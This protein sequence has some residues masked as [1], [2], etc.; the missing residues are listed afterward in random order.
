MQAQSASTLGAFGRELRDEELRECLDI[1]PG[2]I[3]DELVGRA[4]AAAIWQGLIRSR[5]FNC[6]VI[7][8]ARRPHGDRIVCFGAAAFVS[9]TFAEAELS[10]PR[11]CLNSRIIAS[12]ESERSVVLSEA[13]LR[14][15]NARGGL[16]MVILY[17]S[18]RRD[19]L[20]QA[21]VSEVCAVTS[22]RFLEANL[23]YRFNRLLME[24][25][26]A[27][28]AAVNESMHVW[29]LVRR[30]DEF[31]WPTRSFWVVTREDSLNVN[32]SIANP[33][34]LCAEP[35]LRL[36]E[37]DQQ[38][39]LAALTGVTDD[40]LSLR[41]DISVTAVKKR[42]LSVF[43]RTID[44]RPDLFP[45]VDFHKDGQKRGRQKRHHVLAYMRRHP[46]E[47]RPIEL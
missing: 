25:V 8:A 35:V 41:L 11:P 37:V 38:L 32:G 5:S 16:N 44:L 33:I 14:S 19:M 1:N 27:D 12:I 47:L 28:E 10:D 30:F 18:W 42:W 45:V 24:T 20:N 22:A 34:F 4:R 29:R 31:R 46:E 9:Q 21:E 40:E 43:E 7:E 17:G 3:G 15:G 6:T 39:L 2:R 36:R 26:G 13:E 23:G